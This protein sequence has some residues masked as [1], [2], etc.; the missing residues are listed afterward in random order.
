M[1]ELKML[2]Q[3]QKDQ[4]LKDELTELKER[5]NVLRAQRRSLN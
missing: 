5:K 2:L 1:R 3:D 4:K